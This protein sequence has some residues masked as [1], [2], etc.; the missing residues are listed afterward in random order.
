MIRLRFASVLLVILCSTAAAA[1]PPLDAVVTIWSDDQFFGT[2]FFI[3]GDGQILTVYHVIHGAHRIT[4]LHQGT[5]SSNVLVESYAPNRDLAVLRVLDWKKPITY[6]KLAYKLPPGAKDENLM[7][8]GNGAFI[9]NQKIPAWM[10]T[11][12]LRNSQDIRDQGKRVFNFAY[13]IHVIYLNAVVD[14]GLS[15]GPVVSSAGVIGVSLRLTKP[16]WWDR[17]GH[18]ERIRAARAHGACEQATRGDFKVARL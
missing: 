1:E 18:S 4:V 6:L 8:L 15:G 14:V 16:G 5:P 2:G 3:S 17:L 13:N 11:E 12:G 9:E 10:T 7:I